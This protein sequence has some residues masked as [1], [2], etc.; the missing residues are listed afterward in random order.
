[1]P[2]TSKP[3]TNSGEKDF[4]KVV[5]WPVRPRVWVA[6]LDRLGST[7]LV[8]AKRS[9]V[10]GDRLQVFPAASNRIREVLLGSSGWPRRPSFVDKSF[11]LGKLTVSKHFEPG[12]RCTVKKLCRFLV[13][14]W[15]F[16]LRCDELKDH[17]L[18]SRLSFGCLE[19]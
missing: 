14:F 13:I 18:S 10:V 8:A 7:I 2:L 15:R 12:V 3:E 19:E 11:E 9:S 4:G 6:A 16:A 17:L 1:V 5:I